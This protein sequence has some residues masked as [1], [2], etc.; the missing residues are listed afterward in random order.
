MSDRDHFFIVGAQ[1]SGTTYLYHLLDEHPDIEMAKPPRPEPKFFLQADIGRFSHSDYIE[2]FFD[3]TTPVRYR[4]EKSTSYYEYESAA[5]N[6]SAWYPQAKI[7]FV[8]RDPITRAIS[9]YKFSRDNG[10]ETRPL[11]EALYQEGRRATEYDK[12][13]FSTSPFAYL[14]RGLY[15]DYITI[16][17]KYFSDEQIAIHIYEEL[18]GNQGQMSSLYKF[19]GVDPDFSPQNLNTPFNESPLMET[20]ITEQL[21]TYLVNYFTPSRTELEQYLGRRITAWQW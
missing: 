16:Y 9:N 20:P 5:G 13:R 19:L 12:T 1:R 11:E 7:I 14:K 18:I 4:G 15:A 8:L 10:I 6:I 3:Q 17:R 2:K 21:C